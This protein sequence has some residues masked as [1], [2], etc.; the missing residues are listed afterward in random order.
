VSRDG[1]GFVSARQGHEDEMLMEAWFR[2]W[3]ALSFLYSC[4]L[5]P[6]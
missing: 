3:Q 6:P 4:N 1:G 5:V 2:D